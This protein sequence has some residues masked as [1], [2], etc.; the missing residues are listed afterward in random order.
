MENIAQ[1]W[2]RGLKQV[3]GNN[4]VSVILYGSAARADHIP[5]RSDLNLMLVFKKID[6]TQ[7]AKIG[8][9]MPRRIRKK[10]PHL[11]FWT[12]AEIHNA[13]DVFPLEFEDIKENHRC[14]AGKDPFTKRRVNK[15]QMRYQIEFELRSKL[16]SVRENWL[17]IS[18]DRYAL[19]QFLIKAGGSF[20]YLIRHANTFLGKKAVM[21]RDI[22]EKINKVKKKE[23]RLKRVELQALF[24]QLHET[25][26][27]VI[28]RIDAA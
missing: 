27:A 25:V 23:I 26:E 6:L 18:R 3:L 20:A 12:E 22:F 19:E 13:W 14:L 21:P 28:G 8:R 2:A 15:K 24:H 11:V 5:A 10:L 7:I 16:L 17:A 9:L 1:A 4:L